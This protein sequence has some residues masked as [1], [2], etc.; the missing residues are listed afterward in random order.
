MKCFS[1]WQP[2]ATLI[3]IGAKSIETRGW[4]TPYRGPLAIHAAKKRDRDS[5]LLCMEEP[6]RSFLVDAGI[7]KIGDLPFGAIVAV[8]DLV[9]CIEII[10]TGCL[11][12]YKLANDERIYEPEHSFGDYTPGR[13]AWKLANLR[14]LEHPIP[15]IGRQQIF[16]IPDSLI[17]QPM[18]GGTDAC[19]SP[20]D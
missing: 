1:L 9:D 18:K 11:L 10:D 20:T 6:F 17:P 14:R 15:C 13:F 3:A 12:V 19:H 4:Y 8:V 7:Q 2:W 16:N 5:L